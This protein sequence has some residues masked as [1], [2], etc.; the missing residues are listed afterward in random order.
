MTQR[1]DSYSPAA[2]VLELLALL[3]RVQRAEVERCRAALK[4]AMGR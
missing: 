3:E 1:D 2:A 4:A